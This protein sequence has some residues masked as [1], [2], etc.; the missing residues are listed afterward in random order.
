MSAVEHYLLAVVAT[1]VLGLLWVFAERLADG[2]GGRREDSAQPRCGHCGCA[3][4]SNRSGGIDGI[5]GEEA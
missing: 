1:A 2:R 3:G 5:N 4:Q